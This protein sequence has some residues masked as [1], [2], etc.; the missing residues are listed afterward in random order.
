AAY[1]NS[2]R[3][4]GL[5]LPS[6]ASFRPP[7]QAIFGP[8]HP[9]PVRIQECFLG[10]GRL[11]ADAAAPPFPAR[12]HAPQWPSAETSRQRRTALA[13][14]VCFAPLAFNRRGIRATDVALEGLA[15]WP[16]RN[17]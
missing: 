16:V 14:L 13:R 9:A 2:L 12:R 1:R 4:V 10:S 3:Q 6:S 17:Q 7:A 5:G 8:G 11:R 15:E